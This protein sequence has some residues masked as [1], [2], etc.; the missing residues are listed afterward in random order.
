MWPHHSLASHDNGHYSTLHNKLHV[1]LNGP[2]MPLLSI[3]NSAWPRTAHYQAVTYVTVNQLRS[4][5][6]KSDP[7]IRSSL[8][9]KLYL[10]TLLK[11]SFECSI[12]VEA[13]Y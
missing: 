10:E 4:P 2:L 8:S 13:E 12:F 7:Q 6:I 11:F 9:S 5:S 3:T 1:A